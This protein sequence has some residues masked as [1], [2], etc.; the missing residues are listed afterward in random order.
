MMVSNLLS[1]Y[2][3]SAFPLSVI[4]TSTLLG[5]IRSLTK[6]EMELIIMDW[7]S[8]HSRTLSKSPP[9]LYANLC[10][11]AAVNFP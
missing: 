8:S 9:P 10:H 3:S 4:L 6:Y 11:E 2:L 5:I 1:A 7:K